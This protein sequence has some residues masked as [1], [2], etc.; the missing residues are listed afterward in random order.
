MADDPV[1]FDGVR[2][3]YNLGPELELTMEDGLSDEQYVPGPF[4]IA[5][6][7]ISCTVHALSAPSFLTKESMNLQ[8]NYRQRKLICSRR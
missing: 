8:I 7:L 6:H 3:L 1:S 2:P 5:W 4:T